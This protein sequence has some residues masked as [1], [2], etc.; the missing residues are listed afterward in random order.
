MEVANSIYQLGD[1]PGTERGNYWWLDYK[2]PTNLLAM[3]PI[4]ES[5]PEFSHPFDKALWYWHEVEARTA[6]WRTATPAVKVID[7][8]TGWLNDLDRVCDLLDKLGVQYDRALLAPVVWRPRAHQGTS[9]NRRRAS[10]AGSA[11]EGGPIPAAPRAA[12]TNTASVVFSSAD[13][14]RLRRAGEPGALQPHSQLREQPLH[15]PVWYAIQP[16][17]YRVGFETV[18]PRRIV[19][20]AQHIHFRVLAGVPGSFAP[21]AGSPGPGSDSHRGTRPSRCTAF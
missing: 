1:Y 14:H 21:A 18:H 10:G 13:G 4:L 20:H 15:A 11:A 19:D 5:D 17:L 6:A 8:E 16:H 3:A 9:E 12:G 7:F 2:A